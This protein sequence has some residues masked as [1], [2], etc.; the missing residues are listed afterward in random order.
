MGYKEYLSDGQCSSAPRILGAQASGSAPI[1]NNEPVA[2]PETV[3]TAI[4]IGEPAGGCEALTALE[5]SCGQIWSVTDEEILEA[6]R[7]L[8]T[9]EGVFCEPSSAAGVAGL[10]KSIRFGKV[11]LKGTTVVCVLTGHGLKDPDSA[12]AGAE[13]PEAIPPITDDLLRLLE[14][15]S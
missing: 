15:K 11:D 7:L 14:S 6:Y 12:I 3:A 9:T 2:N 1:L 4:R 5:E 10:R 8:A 13:Q